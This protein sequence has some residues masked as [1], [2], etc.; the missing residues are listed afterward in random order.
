MNNTMGK[1]SEKELDYKKMIEDIN[2]LVETDFGEDM[3]LRANI[4]YCGKLLDISQRDAREMA[5]IIGKVYLISHCV[6]CE[7][8][9]VKYRKAL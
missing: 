6:H 3:S 7:S 5:N 4:E 1:G 9:G 2:D 8:C